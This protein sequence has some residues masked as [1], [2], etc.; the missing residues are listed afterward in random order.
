MN[1]VWQE[2][3]HLIVSSVGSSINTDGDITSVDILIM[4]KGKPSPM[5]V[6]VI[7]LFI[8]A[9]IIHIVMGFVKVHLTLLKLWLQLSQQSSIITM[10]QKMC[11]CLHTQYTKS[12]RSLCV[13]WCVDQKAGCFL[14]WNH[15]AHTHSFSIV[16]CSHCLS[17]DSLKKVAL[18]GDFPFWSFLLA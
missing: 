7:L 16:K 1:P 15:S 8:Q 12:V 17:L 4:C 5:P 2:S 11:V 6:L 3:I 14:M 18:N 10:W 9:Y 13:F